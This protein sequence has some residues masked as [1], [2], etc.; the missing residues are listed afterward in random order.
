ML[1]DIEEK[2]VARLQAK[3]TEPKHV[4]IDEAHNALSVPSIDVIAAGGQFQRVAQNYK[5]A[6][7][8][9]VIVTFQHLRSVQDRR[10]GV[11]PLLEAIVAS[12][13]GQTLTLKIDPLAPKRLENITEKEEA[14]DGKI[15]FQIEFETGFI[16]NKL[17][18]AEI[19]DLVTIGLNYYLKPGDAVVD[20]TDEVITTEG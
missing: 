10:K 7:S 8:V 3:I 4:N 9:F 2:I 13:L 19:N 1:T 12:L 17:S 14:E 20:A 6:A 11:Y 15:I 16:I 18:D 5:L